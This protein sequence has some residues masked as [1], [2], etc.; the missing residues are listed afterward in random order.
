MATHFISEVQSRAQMEQFWETIDGVDE[1]EEES[2]E[3]E[4]EKEEK[5]VFV[6]D[7]SDEE[8]EEQGEAEQVNGGDNGDD[9]QS[10]YC[11]SGEFVPR[12]CHNV[13]DC[14]HCPS[15]KQFVQNYKETDAQKAARARRAVSALEVSCTLASQL[16]TPS[17]Y[18]CSIMF[19]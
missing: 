7:D 6:E 17:S 15:T 16:M 2:E 5:S 8:E 4:H 19:F 13:S 12:T 10:F 9:D 1:D 11:T 3:Q 18:F 14:P